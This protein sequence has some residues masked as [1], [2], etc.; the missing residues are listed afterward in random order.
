MIA[1]T[2]S[3]MKVTLLL[4]AGCTG[5]DV[6]S[7]DVGECPTSQ[8]VESW[9]GVNSLE[10]C[11]AFIRTKQFDPNDYVPGWPSYVVGCKPKPTSM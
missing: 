6:E 3:L 8:Y 1:T 9:T 5:T 4:V 7:D 10:E 2:A 11:E